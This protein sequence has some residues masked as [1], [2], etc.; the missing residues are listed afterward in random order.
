MIKVLNK[1]Y[2]YLVF[3]FCLLANCATGQ[4]SKVSIGMRFGYQYNFHQV[5]GSTNGFLPYDYEHVFLKPSGAL[6]V[7]V[8]YLFD[9]RNAIR[10]GVGSS[11]REFEIT[12][13]IDPFYGFV[14]P[15]SQTRYYNANLFFEYKRYFSRKHRIRPFV[16]AGLNGETPFKVVAKRVSVVDPNA[17]YKNVDFEGFNELLLKGQIGFGYLHYLS[18]EFSYELNALVSSELAS[19]F[20]EFTTTQPFGLGLQLLV[21]YHFIRRR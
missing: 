5:I 11:V 19:S 16:Y 14:L 7:N 20:S 9:R 4:H 10:F 17:N 13:A 15:Y 21:N 18:K 6:A 8:E 1:N 2:H 12:G 3:L